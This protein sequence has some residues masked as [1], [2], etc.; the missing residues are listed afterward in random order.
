MVPSNFKTERSNKNEA[1]KQIRLVVQQYPNSVMFSK[2]ALEELTKDNLTTLDAWNVLT[3][4]DAKIYDDGEY[5][6]GSYRYRLET[7]NIVVV[8]A[9][10]SDG[11]GLIIVTA[12][13]KRK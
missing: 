6:Q 9:F 7:N 4:V 12:W 10:S 1:R 13:D 5:C 8:I 2:H 11:L 3:S